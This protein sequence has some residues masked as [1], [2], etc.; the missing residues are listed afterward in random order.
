[1]TRCFCGLQPVRTSL[2]KTL[3]E[4]GADAAAR[5]QDDDTPLLG[6]ARFWS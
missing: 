1:M 6:T 4:E 3:P 5:G 2:V